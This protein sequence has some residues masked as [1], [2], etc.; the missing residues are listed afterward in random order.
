MA[1]AAAAALELRLVRVS[2]ARCSVRGAYGVC[3]FHGV[4]APEDSA[5]ETRRDDGGAT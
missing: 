2:S 1:I 3:T 5:E 4:E